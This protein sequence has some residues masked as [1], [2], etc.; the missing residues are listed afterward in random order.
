MGKLI[1]WENAHFDEVIEFRR[2]FD[3]A[4]LR[5]HGP[6]SMDVQT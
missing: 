2:Q 3:S 4:S 5:A 6:T 1:E